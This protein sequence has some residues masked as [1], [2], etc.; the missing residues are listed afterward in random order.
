MTKTNFS[1]LTN[2]PLDVPSAKRALFLR[3]LKLLTKNTGRLFIFAGDQRVEHL[4]DDFCG[5]DISAEDAHPEHLFKIAASSR[6]GG[7]ATQLG[8]I[9]RFGVTYPNITYIV[10]LNSKS[11]LVKEADQE[12]YSSAWYDVRDVINFAKTSG[13]KIPAVGYTVYAGSGFEA[14]MLREAAQIVHQ[15]HL[16]GLVAII[17]VY[18]RGKAIVDKTDAHLIAGAVNIA[19]AMGADFVKVNSPEPS[20]A[21]GLQEIMAAGQRTGVL[22]AGGE[23]VSYDEL[24]QTIYLHVHRFGG[25]GAALGRNIHQRSFS[26]AVALANAVASVVYDGHAPEVARR[27]LIKQ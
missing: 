16:N 22:F 1:N 17:W 21:D 27:L 11:N 12:P 7:F 9:A 19:S 8:Y 4:N 2:A 20:T 13:L 10:K 15:A 23:A 3:N 18:P 6:I 25:A 24:L 14:A 26:E 5:V